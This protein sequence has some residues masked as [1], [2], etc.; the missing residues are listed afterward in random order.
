MIKNKLPIY[1]IPR[2]IIP[3]D[4]LPLKNSGKINEEELANFINNS[5]EINAEDLAKIILNNTNTEY[6][7]YTIEMLSIDSLETLKLLQVL[8]EDIKYKQIEFSDELL[9]NILTMKIAEIR[10]FIE[11]WRNM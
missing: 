6:E 11:N 2:K 8:S 4:V 9:K 7:D 3:I 5:D 1:M 10:K